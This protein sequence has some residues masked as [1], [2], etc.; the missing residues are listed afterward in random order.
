MATCRCLRSIQMRRKTLRLRMKNGTAHCEAQDSLGE[1]KDPDHSCV[2][3]E[4][5]EMYVVSYFH[6]KGM[7]RPAIAAEPAAVYHED[8]FDENIVKYCLHE[9]KLH[10]SDLSHPLSS[11]RPL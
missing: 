11:G 2:G 7:K 3:K 6:R 1:A 8:A 4:I 5:E 10:R 9:I